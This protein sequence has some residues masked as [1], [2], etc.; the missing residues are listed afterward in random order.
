VREYPLFVSQRQQAAYLLDA[1]RRMRL[2][3]RVKLFTWY[4]LQDSP[5]WSSGLLDQRA[6]P[7]PAHA[8]YSLPVAPLTRGPVR[9]GA[10]IRIVGQVRSARGATRVAIQRRDGGRWRRLRLVPTTR[11]GSFSL[12]VRPRRTASYRVRWSGLT[13][14]G[15]RVARVSAA[16]VLRVR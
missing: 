6:R 4:F 16:F 9:P 10:A 12:T 13:R 1:Y 3:P 11:D 14:T 2:N 7:K 5:F 15:A 8:A